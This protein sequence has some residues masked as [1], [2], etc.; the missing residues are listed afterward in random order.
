MWGVPIERL[1]IHQL[2]LMQCGFAESLECLVRHHIPMTAIWHEKLDEVGVVA[3]RRALSATGIKPVALCIGGTMS[4]RDLTRRAEQIELTHRRIDACAELGIESL[5]ML[6]GGLDDGDT[7][8]MAARARAMD[9]FH[10]VLPAARAAG[11]RLVLEPLHPMVCG[12][13]SVLSTLAA[14]C[15]FLDELGADDA[16][17]LALDTYALWWDLNLSWDIQRAAPRLRHFHVS[18]WLVETKDVRLDRGIPGDG[19]IDNRAIRTAF[20]AVGFT[21]PIEVEILSNARWW[22]VPPDELVAEIIKRAA[23]SL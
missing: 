2:T 3:A 15:D 7:D 19:L 23:Q 20:E 12:F 22:C 1:C 9:G 18:D 21:G 14:G 10:Q 6:T 11:V 4:T 13:R 17:G 5:L 8:L 16:T